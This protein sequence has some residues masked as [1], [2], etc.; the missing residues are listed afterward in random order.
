MRKKILNTVNNFL[1]WQ[2]V[3]W[4]LVRKRVRRVQRRVY[5]ASLSGNVKLVHWLQRNLVYSL[6]AKLLA[7]RIVTT[8]NNRGKKTPGVDRVAAR[9]EDS[10]SQPLTISSDQQNF[11]LAK[12]SS[13]KIDPMRNSRKRK[14]FGVVWLNDKKKFKLA[15]TL[16][17]DQAVA[18]PIRRVWIPKPGKSELRPLGIPT[19]RDRAKQALAKLAL[20]PEWEARFEPNSYGFRPGRRT[21]DAIEAI[22]SSLHHKTPKWV[23]DADIRKC[24]DQIDH[25]ALLE[26]M[27]TFP[28]MRLQV[29]AWLR[30]DIMEGFLDSPVSLT[31]STVG[32]PQGGILSPLLANIALHGLEYHLKEFV[33]S[34]NIKPSPSSNRGRVAKM[35]ALSVIRYADDFVLIHVNKEIID[36]C[37][38]ET[39]KWLSKMNLVI[40][41]EKTALKLG[42]QGFKFLGFQVIQVVKNGEYKVK[43]VPSKDKVLA[44]LLKLREIIQRNKAA[45]SYQL[46]CQ[47]RPIIIGW[48]NYYKF[49][50]CKDTFSKITHLIFQKIRSWVFR[51][52]T[53]HGRLFIK[54]KYFPSGRVYNFGGDKHE[55]NWILTGKDNSKIT[56]EREV[57]L[58][59]MVWVKSVKFVKVIGTKSPFDGDFV[60]WTLRLKSS[61]FL[62]KRVSTLLCRQNAICPACKIRFTSFDTLEVDHVIPLVKGGK[63]EYSNLQLLHREFH[64]KKTKDDLAKPSS[65]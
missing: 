47:I 22:F 24:F 49:C 28:A 48:A 63:N 58:P 62:S 45:S 4:G 60:Y 30:A 12:L 52:D 50:E 3:R 34:L 53:R 17:L 41:S 31:P 20:E 14:G 25:D 40:S 23:Y 56:G 43:I 13:L 27:G 32:T 16:K 65:S 46:I 10:F 7:V 59:H 36:L 39:S 55:D 54:Q 35:K 1:S 5:K 8:L 64:I 15:S 19:I 33:A 38:V 44:L 61:G 29:A 6:D 37:I 51:R 26:K 21:H 9:K 2:S 11:K 57:F 42:S 18:A